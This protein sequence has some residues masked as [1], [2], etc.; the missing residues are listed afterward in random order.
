MPESQR[1]NL[2]R[3]HQFAGVQPAVVAVTLC[4][5]ADYAA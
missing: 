3:G 4:R 5:V 2:A 1:A